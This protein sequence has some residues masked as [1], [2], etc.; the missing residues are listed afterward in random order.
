MAAQWHPSLNDRTPEQVTCGSSRG[1]WWLC[2]KCQCGHDHTWRTTVTK[3]AQQGHGCPICAGSKP[4]RCN[5]LAA[6]HHDTVQQEWDYELNTL[7][8][9]DLLPQSNVV[10]HWLCGLHLP[11]YCWQTSPNKRFCRVGTGCPECARQRN[12]KTRTSA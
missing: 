5:S 4:C 2:K 7:S 10:V 9:E 6:I 12:R 3:R 1:V 11:H 8:P